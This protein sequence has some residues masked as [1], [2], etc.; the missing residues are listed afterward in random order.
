[1]RG[2]LRKCQQNPVYIMFKSV[3]C[4]ALCTCIY[5]ILYYE[6]RSHSYDMW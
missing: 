6:V 4:C 3:K 5:I 2:N 1:M